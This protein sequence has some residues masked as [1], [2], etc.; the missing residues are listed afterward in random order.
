MVVDVRIGDK[1]VFIIGYASALVIIREGYFTKQEARGCNCKND[2]CRCWIGSTRFVSNVNTGRPFL[3]KA[4]SVC[5]VAATRISV[6]VAARMKSHRQ[7]I[8]WSFLEEEGQ[9]LRQNEEFGQTTH[10]SV[11]P[12][13][14]IEWVH[15]DSFGIRR[16]IAHV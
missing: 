3:V 2:T 6:D 4:C 15:L 10:P 7:L 12:R 11:W 13:L 9:Y 16:T 8:T 5:D 14:G 1:E